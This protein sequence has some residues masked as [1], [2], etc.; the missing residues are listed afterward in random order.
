[1][2][3]RRQLFSCVVAASATAAAQDARPN[4]LLILMDD[5]AC[6][7]LGCYGGKG[8]RTPNLDRLAAAGIRFTDAYA[9]PQCT[10]TRATL[11]SGQYTARNRMWHVIP[12]YGL[13]WARVK[14]P[15]YATK[16]PREKFTLAKGL[17]AAG[18]ATACIGKWH[19]T[20][21]EDGNYNSLFPA[22]A[23]HYGF[24]EGLAP[25]PKAAMDRDR[26][27]DLLT[28][29]AIAF[30]ETNRAKPWFCYLP[31]HATHR[32]LAAPPELVAKY[33]AQGAPETG[34]GNALALASIEHMDQA[35]GRLLDHIGALGLAEKTCVIF[36]ADN[37]GVTDTYH[38][39]PKREGETWKLEQR[40]GDIDSRP[41]RAGKGFAYEGGI[42]VPMIVRWKGK[43]KPGRVEQTPVHLVDLAPTL[44]ALAAAKAPADHRFEGA[45]LSALWTR[46]TNSSRGTKLPE[47][48]LYWYMP[49]YDL[50]WAATPCAVI[51]QGRH[52]LIE[53]FG[54]RF[55]P[56]GGHAIYRPGHRLELF[57]LA[58]DPGESRNL[59]ADQP[60][61][62]AKLQ[63]QL[64]RWIK[65]SGAE[66]PGANPRFDPAREFEETRVR[67]N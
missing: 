15:E 17:R 43:V 57:D 64:H 18:Y 11:M 20:A 25:I 63:S 38:P 65:E 9:T 44:L 48:P 2:L 36:T 3:T 49:L 56:S 22:A 66:V 46:G 53:Y 62:A 6:Q 33:R 21:D 58:R 30:I 34:L 13:P 23:A 51:R 47:R 40:P 26:A 1:M 35:I 10:P 59:A 54:D 50:R 4:F 7:A 19:L 16:Y 55:E 41:F 5:M 61:L 60:A 37:G 31:H 39:Q 8:V 29:R 14:E 67:P 45:D 32:V 42:R 24:D 28:D 27:V 52:K 12:W